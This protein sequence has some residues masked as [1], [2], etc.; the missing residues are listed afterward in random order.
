MR[1][2]ILLSSIIPL[3]IIFGCK[4][5]SVADNNLSAKDNVLIANGNADNTIVAN[6]T[7]SVE[8]LVGF[9]ELLNP[10]GSNPPLPNGFTLS[11]LSWVAGAPQNPP[12]WIYIEGSV[13]QSDAKTARHVRIT[14]TLAILNCSTGK[15]LKLTITQIQTIP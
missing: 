7:V 6:D 9:L 11:N 3:L 5:E 2:L 4:K 13:S 15:Y 8:G 1:T 14:G 12:S 10:P